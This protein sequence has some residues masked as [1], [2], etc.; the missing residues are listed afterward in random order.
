MPCVNVLSL[1]VRL[2]TT[3][4]RGLVQAGDVIDRVLPVSETPSDVPTLMPTAKPVIVNPEMETLLAL[5]V[6]PF[7]PE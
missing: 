6:M 5:T 1:T 3:A 4:A 7:V 2:V